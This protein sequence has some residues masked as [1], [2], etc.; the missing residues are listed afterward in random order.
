MLRVYT[1]KH[2]SYKTDIVMSDRIINA[3][4]ETESPVQQVVTRLR[5]L[6]RKQPRPYREA[7][8]A[9]QHVVDQFNSAYMQSAEHDAFLQKVKQLRVNH[10]NDRK[11]TRL[12]TPP[13]QFRLETYQFNGLDIT[14]GR[15]AT[16]REC[17]QYLFL[18]LYDGDLALMPKAEP[19]QAEERAE[20]QVGAA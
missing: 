17:L 8:N 19:K 6:L 2:A 18:T 20:E 4:L 10:A 13:K 15:L 9:K 16:L 7:H 5:K 12:F 11:Q 3:A 14:P 1:I